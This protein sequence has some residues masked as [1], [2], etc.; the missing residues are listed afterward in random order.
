MNDMIF[1]V[2]M[3]CPESGAPTLRLHSSVFVNGDRLAKV[4]TQQV[5]LQA[6]NAVADALAVAMGF[7]DADAYAAAYCAALDVA[8]TS[9]RAENQ[10]DDD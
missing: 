9:L 3:E 10:G 7:A 5:V 8:R 6:G 1:R 2:E 4:D